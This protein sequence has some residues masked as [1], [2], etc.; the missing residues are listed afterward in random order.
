MCATGEITEALD[1]ATLSHDLQDRVRHVHETLKA[2]R[3][4]R[5][6]V[7]VIDGTHPLSLAGHWVPE[8]VKRAGG[9]AVLGDAGAHSR[10]VSMDMLRAAD[11]EILVFAP[12]GTTLDAAAAEARHCLTLVVW[13]WAVGRHIWAI[14]ANS[15]TSRPGPCVVNGIETLARI[16]NPDCFSPLD[17]QYACRLAF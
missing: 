3:A 8:Q 5:P 12:C 11:P 13:Q 2:A 4:P 15:L 14:D 17:E 9:I 16:F 10:V 6:R 7:A 1:V